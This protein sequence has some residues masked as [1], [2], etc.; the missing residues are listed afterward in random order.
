MQL[1]P[2]R[3]DQGREMGTVLTT[4]SAQVGMATWLEGIRHTP[5][6]ELPEETGDIITDFFSREGQDIDTVIDVARFGSSI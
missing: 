4:T 2:S 3:V 6:D 5:L 1:W